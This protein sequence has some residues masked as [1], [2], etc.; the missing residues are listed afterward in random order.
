MRHLGGKS[1]TLRP[2]QVSPCAAKSVT[3]AA[4]HV[5]DVLQ[6]NAHNLL[7]SLGNIARRHIAIF[8]PVQCQLCQLLLFRASSAGVRVHSLGYPRA[9][10]A[11]LGALRAAVR[12]CEA[13]GF[14]EN[15]A[16]VVCGPARRAA[17]ANARRAHWRGSQ[18]DGCPRWRLKPNKEHRR[19]KPISTPSNACNCAQ[20]LYVRRFTAPRGFSQAGTK[21]AGGA[22]RWSRIS[23]RSAANER[24]SACRIT[25]MYFSRVRI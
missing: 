4:W 20:K 11:K 16:D 19:L 17:S 3:F 7:V 12:P 9:L 1:V 18:A 8:F 5:A 25:S 13:C 14:G 2:A 10:R 24:T 6:R 21:K 23:Q 15:E 22:P